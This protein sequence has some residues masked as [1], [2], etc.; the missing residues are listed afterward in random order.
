MKHD[1]NLAFFPF[2]KCAAFVCVC[3][4]HENGKEHVTG[5]NIIK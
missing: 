1:E 2:M 3:L 5:V 4:V